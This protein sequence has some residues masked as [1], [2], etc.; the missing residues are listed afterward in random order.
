MKT[1]VAL[2]TYNGEKYLEE[3]IDSILSQSQTVD[4]IIICDDKSTD[5]TYEIIKNYKKK[6]PNLFSIYQNEKNLGYVSN[7]EK[8]LALANHDVVFLCDQDDIWYPEKVE[9]CVYYFEKNI[10]INMI[11]HNLDLL[12]FGSNTH[13]FWSLKNFTLEEQDKNNEELLNR[14]LYKGNVFPGMT[15]AIKTSALQNYLPLKKVDKILIHDFELL[16]QFLKDDQFALLP[17]ILAA[18]RKHDEQSIGYSESKENESN[19]LIKLHHL[20]KDYQRLTTYIQVFDLPK[21]VAKDFQSS[22]QS[23]YNNYLE[24]YSFI[25]RVFLHLKHKYYHQIIKF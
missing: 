21:S 10:N 19:M 13:N 22:A 15:M 9:K 6:Y 2:C 7:F 16:I 12:N 3:Q 8:A 24:N 17:E 18:Y 25:K 11:A 4:E 23:T 14:V 1:S 5:S 20:S